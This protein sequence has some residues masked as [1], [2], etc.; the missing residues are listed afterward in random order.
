[1]AVEDQIQ[2]VK[3]VITA[4]LPTPPALHSTSKARDLKARLEWG[5][6]ALT[7]IDVRDRDS[8]NKE[9]ITGAMPMPLDELTDLANGIARVRDIYV[10]GVSDEETAQAANYLRAAGFVNVAEL[11]GGLAAWK[12]IEGLTDGSE[13]HI[14]P[15]S[16]AYN[17]VSRI[18]HH[19]EVQRK[20]V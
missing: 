18:A 15:N 4:P 17:V 19:Q 5:E 12:T 3:E 16:G 11:A 1:M 9:H 14:Q 20:N 2:S 10:Y 13:V 6:P 8:F 7:I